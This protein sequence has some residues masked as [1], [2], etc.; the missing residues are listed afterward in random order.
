MGHVTNHQPFALGLGPGRCTIFRR[1]QK[2]RLSAP[3]RMA[4]SHRGEVVCPVWPQGGNW[5]IL[6][7]TPGTLQEAA[8]AGRA[9]PRG[10]RAGWA[11]YACSTSPRPAPHSRIAFQLRPS[12][13]VAPTTSST[14]SF[15]KTFM[16]VRSSD[17][18]KKAT[19][20]GR[21]GEPFFKTLAK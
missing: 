9:V 1:T 8:P 2:G 13:G 4:P 18:A 20:R 7:L 17:P 21:A 12:P 11:R 16:V 15:S 5:V 3:L 19:A 14:N 10:A 6:V